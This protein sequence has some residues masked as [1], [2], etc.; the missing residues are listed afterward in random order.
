MRMGKLGFSLFI[1]GAIAYLLDLNTYMG[2]GI[3]I[4]IFLGVFYGERKTSKEE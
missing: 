4:G 1:G 2:I 3:A